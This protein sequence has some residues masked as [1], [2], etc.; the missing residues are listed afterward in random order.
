M[1]T[2]V[3][4]TRRELGG[5]AGLVG[6]SDT[7]LLP[8]R[9]RRA[10]PAGDA[11]P[12]RGTET[13]TI[14]EI[15]R[16]C[17][18]S[19]A[20]VSKVLNGREGV[21][22]A[23]RERVQNIIVE[24]DYQR[25]GSSK[26]ETPPIVDLVFDALDSPWAMEI[27]RGAVAAAHEAGLT[28]AL[29]SLSEGAERISWFDHVTARGTRGVI[30]LLSRLSTRQKAELRSRRLP[31]AVVDP[32]GEPD[33]DVPT[34]GATNWSGGLTAT[35]HLLELGHE[36]IAMIG[37]PTDLLCSRARLDGYRAAMEG[38]GYAIDP[39]LVRVGDFRV[40]GGFKEAMALLSLP[41]PPSAIFA[42][43]DLQ[44]LGV[45]EAARLHHLRVPSELSLV[46]FDD[47]PLSLWTSPPITTVRQPLA[48][49]ASAAV[50]LV[51]AEG[52]GA[53][54]GSSV[55]LATSLVVRE[56]TARRP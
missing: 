46:G 12:R 29:T 18:V 13:V 54:P 40:E 49:M 39:L 1:A 45:L 36:R 26:T 16:E 47:L 28:V 25:R 50:R 32:R 51:L 53:H 41:E 20:T 21:S 27:V 9:R 48:E 42:G 23:T 17:G 14:V 33:P 35:R 44:A 4:G 5:A 11:A 10:R 55:E 15:A 30:V 22:R 6:D 31:F 7:M 19:P 8:A 2:G 24:H 43:S 37:G 52:A 34:V 38:A 56:S 3:R